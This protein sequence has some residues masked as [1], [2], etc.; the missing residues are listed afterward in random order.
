MGIFRRV[1]ILYSNSLTYE[2]QNKKSWISAL[3]LLNAQ[4]QK[5]KYKW[6]KCF[7]E[8]LFKFLGVPIIVAHMF[9]LKKRIIS[10][11]KFWLNVSI[12]FSMRLS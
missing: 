5:I 6:K 10:Q 4:L 8:I 3:K 12:F 11:K 1:A 9:L 7:S 2:A